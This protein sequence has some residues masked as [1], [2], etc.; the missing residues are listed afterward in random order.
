MN[1]DH[2]RHYR[3]NQDTFF[4]AICQE[5]DDDWAYKELSEVIPELLH[6]DETQKSNNE[7]SNMLEKIKSQ[8]RPDSSIKKIICKLSLD[9]IK[10]IRILYEKERP[11]MEKKSGKKYPVFKGK[12]VRKKEDAINFMEDNEEIFDEF[13]NRHFP[14]ITKDRI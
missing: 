13:I 11:E 2:W 12:L 4:D 9:G 10:S 8:S 3:G 14:W 7:N 1:S 5:I 6:K